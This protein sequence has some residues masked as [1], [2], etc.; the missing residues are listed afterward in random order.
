[1]LGPFRRSHLCL[2]LGSIL[3][4]N[5]AGL[6]LALAQEPD[7][8]SNPKPASTDS[9]TNLPST[10]FGLPGEDPPKEFVPAHP[11]T[12]EQQK[13]VE[14]LRYYAMG[15]AL[16]ERRQFTAAIKLYENALESQ[17]DSTS[18]LRRLSLINF[19]LGRDEPGVAYGKRA[20]ENEP[21]DI[22]TIELLLRHFRKDPPSAEA[23]L[24][25][26]AK[27]PK[28]DKKSIGALFVEFE[29][30]NFFEASLQYDKAAA[31]FAKVV[32]AIDDKT[33]SKLA[34]ADLRRFLGN[35][36]A[37]SYLR[38]GRVFLQAKQKDQAIKAFQRGLVYE[39]DEPLL[40]L[41]LS[42]TYLESGKPEEALAQVER[43]LKRQPQG[44]EMYDLF[45]RILITLKRENE[46]LPRLEKYAADSPKNFPLQYA[47][48]ERYRQAGLPEKAQAIITRLL[49]EQRDTQDFVEQFPKLLKEKKYEELLQLVTR[50]SGRIRQ[51]DAIQP[52]LDQILAEPEAI[53]SVLDTGLK[54]LASNPPTLEIAEG[55]SI[56]KKIALDAQK[57]DKLVELL[58]WSMKQVQNPFATYWEIV[59]TYEQAKKYDDA[60]NTWKE[61]IDRFPDQRT[62]RSL[63]L[64]A[65]IQSAGNKLD[66]AIETARE[67]Y[68]L[69]PNDIF[70]LQSIANLLMRAD[71]ADEAVAILQDRLKQDPNNADASLILGSILT[72]AH[73][74]DQAIAVY[75][76][77]IDRFA[78]NDE[79]TKLAHS[80]LSIVYTEMNDFP[81]AE[82]ELETI[83]ARDPNDP[84]VNNDLGYLYADQGKNL[85]KAEA[86]IRKAVEEEPNN[87]AY[88]DSLGWVLFKRGK[89]QEARIPLEKAQSDPREDA[90]LP[91]HLGD[92]YFQLQEL[93][94][95]KAAWEKALKIAT[96]S[97]PP[98]KKLGEI[99]KKLESLQ[100][101]VPAPKPKTGN[102]P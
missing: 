73:R 86:M 17:P 41:F 68:K 90:T 89:F 26:I 99:K 10:D 24:V 61:M 81:K 80:S 84:G 93:G 48:A 21:G 66:T 42:Q 69:E 46:I 50:V 64:L 23:L 4:G 11:R 67:A 102:A 13:Q 78:N 79:I 34:P 37:Q 72:R 82:A 15:R 95:A 20:L 55:F 71:K 31:A 58:R 53:D 92:V 25:D 83:F 97:K 2:A 35:D 77:M 75:K 56:L 33:N 38:F 62:A 16:E 88:L 59:L 28:L 1:M 52:Q 98:D 40:L 32:E 43:F 22:E 57:Y 100:N 29:L 87:F 60:E 47:L 3:L 49:A 94:K 36:E 85:E 45:A 30:G 27:N 7:P 74:T 51:I 14:A 54:M 18:V 96:E 63:S 19:A 12:V 9:P 44:R 39:P 6:T 8:K 101:F 5:S 65:R 76:G 70:A 91:D